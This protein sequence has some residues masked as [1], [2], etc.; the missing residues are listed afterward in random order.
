MTFTSA[1]IDLARQLHAAGLPWNPAAGHYVFDVGGVVEKPSPFQDGVYFILN[2]DYFMTLLGGVDAFR[3]EMV[4]LPT[5]E[6]CR[7]VLASIGIEDDRVQERL[8]A[9]V[10][11]NRTERETLY[12]MILEHN[13]S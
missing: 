5:W 10:F 3:A 11:A 4:W 12:R 2:Y 9:D 7:E 13:D 1:E 6:Q 8:S